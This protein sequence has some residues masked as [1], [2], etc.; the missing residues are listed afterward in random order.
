MRKH[1]D[2]VQKEADFNVAV[3]LNGDTNS[4]RK[5]QEKKKYSGGH[6]PTTPKPLL[7]D[8][9]FTSCIITNDEYTVSKNSDGEPKPV[10]PNV[11]KKGSDA[12]FTMGF[13]PPPSFSLTNKVLLREPI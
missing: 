13:E 2:T 10:K 11:A 5:I 7:G 3:T 1:G 6:H 4:P 8:M 9:G 12:I